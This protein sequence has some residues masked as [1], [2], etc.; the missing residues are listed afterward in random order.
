LRDHVRGP[1]P[2][3]TRSVYCTL[4]E[5]ELKPSLDE[6]VSRHQS[7]EVG[8]YPKWFD[9]HY[10]TRLTIDGRTLQ[11]VTLAEAHLLRLLGSTVT[12]PPV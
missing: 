12:K 6:V 11:D 3:F 2:F 5:G 1:Q 10:K 8:S 7:V 4:E 9:P